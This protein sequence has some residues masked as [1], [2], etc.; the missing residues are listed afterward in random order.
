MVD[1][2]H[3]I[4]DRLKSVITYARH[5]SAEGKKVEHRGTRPPSRALDPVGPSLNDPTKMKRVEKPP[6]VEAF[7]HELRDH[8]AKMAKD[9]K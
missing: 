8:F 9:R 1:K 5:S 7:P 2:I 6:K 3:E 4:P